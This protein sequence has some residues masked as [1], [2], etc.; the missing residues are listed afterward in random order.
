MVM[1]KRE[2][3]IRTENLRTNTCAACIQYN[4]LQYLLHLKK[5]KAPCDPFLQSSP[6]KMTNNKFRS[7]GRRNTL[8][9]Y[10]WSFK[11]IY[12]L[13]VY[14]LIIWSKLIKL[15]SD[16]IDSYSLLFCRILI[17]KSVF[18]KLMLN[19]V[20]YLHVHICLTSHNH[21]FV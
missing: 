1:W 4:M 7:G 2:S 14:N 13:S 5:Y 19:Q 16:C 6:W 18:K 21:S 20:S 15:C 3:K 12:N 10:I 8:E 17:F 9:S 11:R